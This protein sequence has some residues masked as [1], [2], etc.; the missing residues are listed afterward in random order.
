MEK[1]Y[2]LSDHETPMG[3]VAFGSGSCSTIEAIIAHQKSILANSAFQFRV[4]AIVTDNKESKA[5]QIA[6]RE[7]IPLVY[8]DLDQFMLDRK[9]DPADKKQRRDLEMRT[10]YDERTKEM[11]LDSCKR[12]GFRIDIIALA[13]YML[14]L[15]A[16]IINGFAGKIINSHPADLSLRDGEGKRSY[17]GDNAVLDAIIAGEQETRT[18]IHLVRSKVDAG[19]ILALSPP[20]TVD[21]EA[22]RI[23]EKVGRHTHTL[24]MIEILDNEYNTRKVPKDRRCFE[25]EAFTRYLIRRIVATQHQELQKR[26]CDYPAYCFV[27]DALRRGELALEDTGGNLKTVVYR[28]ERMPYSGVVMR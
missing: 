8:N 26:V 25:S 14:R 28:D 3:V 1:I 9:M 23:L 22:V 12:R 20:L 19:E 5:H 2:D 17:T 16:P 4:V 6:E 7:Q 27:I 10:A 21:S 15:H 11:M 13:G 18:T 24:P